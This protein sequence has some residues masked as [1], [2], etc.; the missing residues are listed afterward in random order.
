RFGQEVQ[1]IQ[2]LGTTGRGE[3][4]QIGTYIEKNVDHELSGNIIDLCPVGAL[5]NKP[6]R[7]SARSWEMMQQPLVGGH[8]CVGSNLFAH[9]LRGTVKRV[10]PRPNDAINETWISDRDRF[11]YEGI[12]AEDRLT[13]PKIRV[14]G[15]WQD[16]D[17]QTALAQA[18]SLLREAG[19]GTSLAVSP[20][21]TLEEGWLLQ[22]VA[23]GLG[24]ANIDHRLHRRDTHDQA[25]EPVFPFLGMPIAQ[26]DTLDA[27]LVVGSHLRAEAPI[28]AHRMRKAVVGNAARVAFMDSTS[29]D[30]NFELLAN[31]AG[32][33][34][35]ELLA[36]ASAVAEM[37]GTTLD[38]RMIDALPAATVRED[39]KAVAQ[40]LVEGEQSLILLGVAAAS[41]ARFSELRWLATQLSAMTGATLGYLSAGPNAAGLSLA[42]VLPH[43][44]AAGV[45][46]TEPGQAVREFVTEP[47]AAVM[48]WHVD[49]AVDL[50]AFE[51]VK[52]ALAKVP[53]IACTPY[54]SGGVLE[55][56]DVILPVGTYAESDGTFVNVE[57]LAQTW[58]AVAKPVGEAREG[59]K[60]LTVLG[61]ALALA[62]FDYTN[63]AA[64]T[65]EVLGAIDLSTPDNRDYAGATPR[66]VNGEDHPEVLMHRPLYETDEIVRRARALQLTEAGQTGQL[67][68]SGDTE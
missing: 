19:T 30:Y 35:A 63:S 8:D 12:Y 53:V 28:L 54:G 40:A 50:A 66:S 3:N 11:S 24:T 4:M 38:A 65:A 58:Q 62:G 29:R 18:A 34:C 64:L 39:H 44:G 45:A 26:L 37:T 21:A 33:L 46:R 32:G 25:A 52:G 6:Y 27:A 51:G 31:L 36:V 5:N 10:V 57:G 13:G 9:T 67:T 48:L 43:R 2:E 22:R 14:D 15:E 49:P 17:W 1:G 56:A 23:E 55:V 47:G 7:Y 42:G 61:Q 68:R 59:W 20:Q 41:H 60:V 16:C